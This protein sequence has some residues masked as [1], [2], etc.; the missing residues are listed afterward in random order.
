MRITISGPPGSGKTTV[1]KLLSEKLGMKY[2]VSGALFRNMAEEQGLTLEE[3]GKLAEKD[4]KFD[5]MLDE[6]MLRIARENDSIILEGRLTGYLLNKN[7]IDAFKIYLD[8]ELAERSKR[9]SVRDGIDIDTAREK[10]VERERC[11]AMRYE[12]YYGF[13]P[14]DRSFYDLVID[15]TRLSP[16]EV[17]LK[18]VKALEARGWAEC[19]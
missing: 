1:C 13:D 11:E 3:F 8:A 16:E 10:I 18:I 19:S 7:G 2:V 5:R 9:A 4:P 14:A 6:Q 17:V 15:T 12:R